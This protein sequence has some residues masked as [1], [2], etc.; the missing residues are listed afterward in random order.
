MERTAVHVD[1][2]SLSLSLSLSLF[3]CVCV[4]VCVSVRLHVYGMCISVHGCAWVRVR[5]C[6]HPHWCMQA[7]ACMCVRACGRTS[8]PERHVRPVLAGW[9][10]INAALVLPLLKIK[11]Y[12]EA[13]AKEQMEAADAILAKLET[14]LAKHTYL[15]G[16]KLTAADVVLA[17][18]LIR[19]YLVV[20]PFHPHFVADQD[21]SLSLSLSLSLSRSL[22]LSLSVCVCV[23]VCVRAR[24]RPL[25]LSLS[26]YLSHTDRHTQKVQA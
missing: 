2:L 3:L 4:C 18:Q 20:C 16:E 22:S 15:V 26:L 5:T 21:G 10:P 11:P 6:M 24:V 8:V 19:L 17:G 25:S 7:C 14:H 12:S 9:E 13:F 23:C 1:A